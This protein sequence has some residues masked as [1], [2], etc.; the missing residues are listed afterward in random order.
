MDLHLYASYVNK[1]SSLHLYASLQNE[2]GVSGGAALTH[3]IQ[4]PK[5]LQGISNSRITLSLHDSVCRYVLV[6]FVGFFSSMCTF[7]SKSL[8]SYIHTSLFMY[9]YI[10]F[11]MA[12]TRRQP[13]YRSSLQDSV[14]RCAKNVVTSLFV[15]WRLFCVLS[16]HIAPL[17]RIPFADVQ[18]T[19]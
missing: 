1:Y 2:V 12:L 8:F 18:K 14:C 7:F 13:T 16:I 17:A 11:D 10:P 4:H 15:Y 5:T 9:T 3:Q 19:W 6:S